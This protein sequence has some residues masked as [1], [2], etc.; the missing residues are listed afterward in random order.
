MDQG[1]KAQIFLSP[2]PRNTSG[3][4]SIKLHCKLTLS[5][6]NGIAKQH[7]N[8]ELGYSIHKLMNL[9]AHSYFARI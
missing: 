5:D 4:N 6:M 7:K 3:L 8:I 2:I 9:L 1:L